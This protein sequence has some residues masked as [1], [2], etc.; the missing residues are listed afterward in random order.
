MDETVPPSTTRMSEDSVLG[1][2]ESQDSDIEQEDDG[3]MDDLE[4]PSRPSG[5]LQRN[6]RMHADVQMSELMEGTQAK[7]HRGEGDQDD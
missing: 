1:A 2:L 5:Y 3:L 6:D 7:Q 4:N